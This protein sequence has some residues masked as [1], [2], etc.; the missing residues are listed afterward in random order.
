MKVG[1][2]DSGLGGLTIFRSMVEIAP[3]YDY[4]YLGDS[5]RTPYGNRSFASILQFTREAVEYLFV[6]NCQ[7]VIL[8]CNTAS[9]KALRTLQQ[10]Y[11]PQHYPNRRILGVI[12]PSV[13]AL[14]N[15]SLHDPN[16]SNTVA[17]WGTKGTISS[18]SYPIEL[19]HLA[20]QLKVIQQACPLLVPLIENQE[21]Q[22]VGFEYFVEQ[23]WK[24]TLLKG[25]PSHLLL[26]CTHYP[27]A[28]HSIQK[29]IGNTVHILTQGRIVAESWKEYLQR[30][31]EWEGKLSQNGTQEFTTTEDPKFFMSQAKLF[32]KKDITATKVLL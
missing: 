2:F 27:L 3:Q 23:Y 18:Q 7:I 31:P 32:L 16:S 11:L 25:T 10:E 13:E 20:P 8:A 1:V 14:S 21:T 6:Q 15:H 12:R 29:H 9:A 24:Q 4:L 26:A 30:H 28:L 5:A 22:H 17:I 19:S